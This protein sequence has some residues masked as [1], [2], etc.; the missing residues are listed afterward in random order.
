M[1]WFLLAR[2]G[3][4]HVFFFGDLACRVLFL[5]RSI[6]DP[7]RSGKRDISVSD[8]DLFAGLVPV[9]VIVD[10]GESADGA[11]D[12]VGGGDDALG[13]FDEEAEGVARLVH[14]PVEEAEGV[15][16]SINDATVGQVEFVSDDGRAVPVKDAL[17]DGFAFGVIADGTVG[18]VADEGAVGSFVAATEPFRGCAGFAVGGSQTRPYVL[19]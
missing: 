17:L 16:V 3:L 18:D 4:A 9:A 6:F 15:G 12:G 7:A 2:M 13:L 8:D 19:W 14:A 11:N 10:A 1:P 5:A